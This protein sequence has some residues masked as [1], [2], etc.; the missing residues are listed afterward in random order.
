[1]AH[2]T[3]TLRDDWLI[4]L[5]DEARQFVKPGQLVDIR[6]P[7]TH[8]G[9]HAANL[10]DYLGDFIGAVE[11]SGTNN[12]EDTGAKFGAYLAAKQIEGRL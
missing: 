8:S 12:S 9:S 10:A 1:M 4:E 2:F 6:L 11:G 7:D 5:P 3:A